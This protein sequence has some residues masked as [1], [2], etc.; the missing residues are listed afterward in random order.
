[1][2][3]WLLSS[4][5]SS[6][7]CV[8]FLEGHGR[9]FVLTVACHPTAPLLA[10]GGYKNTVRLWLLSS[11]NSSATCV[12]TLT[13]YS[14]LVLSVAFHPTAPLLATGSDDN[15]VKLWL[16]SSDNSSVTCVATLKGH[17]SSVWSVAF[18]PTAPGDPGCNLLVVGS[19]NGP[20]GG[21][22][23]SIQAS[24][25]AELTVVSLVR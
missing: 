22:A 21:S 15:T 18:H 8:A 2:R 25:K 24:P 23:N 10:T 19:I 13:G 12:A 17:N 9:G 6:A 11:D 3:L 14:Y 5:Y 7:T 4:D 1:V 16:L 20:D